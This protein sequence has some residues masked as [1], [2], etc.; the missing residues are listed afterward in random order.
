MRRE[1]FEPAGVWFLDVM[2]VGKVFSL[3][4]F[5]N[6]RFDLFKL[7]FKPGWVIQRELSF[8]FCPI[9]VPGLDKFRI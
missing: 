9:R 5:G 6:F 4:S 1:T 2:E 7:Q 3:Y 8:F